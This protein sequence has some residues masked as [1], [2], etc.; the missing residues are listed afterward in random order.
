[1]K[2]RSYLTANKILSVINIVFALVSLV[3]VILGGKSLF[4][5]VSLYGEMN[6]D[7][8]AIALYFRAINQIVEGVRFNLEILLAGLT[9]F[10]AAK[11]FKLVY[12]KIREYL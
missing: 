6:K 8:P 10:F 11:N 2:F 7:I 3:I 1:M 5:T 12:G 4:E 9:M